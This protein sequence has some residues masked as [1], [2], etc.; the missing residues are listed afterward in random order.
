[1]L[2]SPVRILT[3]KMPPSR[4]WRDGISRSRWA[5]AARALASR[6]ADRQAD[7]AFLEL[8]LA[9]ADLACRLVDAIDPVEVVLRRRREFEGR[10]PARPAG[11]QS[12]HPAPSQQP[13]RHGLVHRNPDTV[14]IPCANRATNRNGQI[15][16][17]SCAA[18]RLHPG[19]CHPGANAFKQG[20]PA[21]ITRR[22][23]P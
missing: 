8:E 16:T 23:R 6:K 2:I 3:R 13:S 1:M 22:F 21:R 4:S 15:L 12:Q 9:G 10:R 11:T 20:T 17:G 14:Q 18:F 19:S 5:V 7:A